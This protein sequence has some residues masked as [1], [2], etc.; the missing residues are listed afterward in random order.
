MTNQNIEVDVLING[1][2]VKQFGQNGRVFIEARVDSEYSIKVRN[3][4]S[5]R[6]LAV[7]SVDGVNVVNGKNANLE[8]TGYIIP[9]YSAVDIQGYRR[10]LSSVGA[11]KFTKKKKAY[12]KQVSGTT[13]NVGVI[14]VAV[15]KEKEKPQPKPTVVHHWY[16]EVVEKPVY[17]PYPTYRYPTY[18]YSAGSRNLDMRSGGTTTST[19]AN[20]GQTYSANNENAKSFCSASASAAASADNFSTTTDWCETE[21]EVAPRGIT[22]TSAKMSRS[23]GAGG[24]SAR[25]CQS[26]V[27]E[28]PKF[29]VGSSWGKEITNQ[30]K[31]EDFVKDSSAPFTIL[32]IFYDTRENLEDIGIDFNKETK[33]AFPQGFPNQFAT[34]PVN[35]SE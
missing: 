17:Y 35:W 6:V 20:C 32:D 23:Y 24:Q 9:G 14:S 16:T 11:F 3:S 8:G 29:E 15:F 18:I 10:D 12:A 4:N 31:T 27:S 1:R 33:V 7:V 19:S 26:S 21:R 34:P 30:V 5:Y 28:T 2:P 25:L 22:K 13:Q